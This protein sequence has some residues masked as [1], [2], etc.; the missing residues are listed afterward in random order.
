MNFVVRG[1]AGPSALRSP[2]D[3]TIKFNSDYLCS[4]SIELEFLITK[5]TVLS[6]SYQLSASFCVILYSLY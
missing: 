6:E 1:D 2:L 5:Y 3:G 4:I